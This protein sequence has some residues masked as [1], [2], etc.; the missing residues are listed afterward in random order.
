MLDHKLIRSHF[1]A[2]EACLEKRHASDDMK[3]GL[4][5][6]SSV[7]NRRRELQTE[8]DDLRAQRNTL[9]K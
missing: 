3:T 2:V 8:T 7:L 4:Q 1:E 5:R 9:T 6:L